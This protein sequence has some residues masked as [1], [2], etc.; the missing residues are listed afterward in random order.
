MVLVAPTT[1]EENIAGLV[2][3]FEKIL[4]RMTKAV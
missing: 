4:D 1:S 2:A 3:S